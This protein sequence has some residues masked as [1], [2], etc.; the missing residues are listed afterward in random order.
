MRAEGLSLNH[1]NSFG[2]I[3]ANPNLEPCGFFNPHYCHKKFSYTVCIY[4]NTI[5][6]F[7]FSLSG[8]FGTL[9]YVYVIFFCLKFT[10]AKG[11]I[12]VLKYPFRE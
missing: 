3:F 11:N 5:R 2:G 10:E 9:R 8:S 7:Y 4:F 1:V 12:S 6:E